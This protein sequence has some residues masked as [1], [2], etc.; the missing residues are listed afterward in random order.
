MKHILNNIKNTSIRIQLISIFI[1]IGIAIG[2]VTVVSLSLNYR[3]IDRHR[4]DLEYMLMI[5]EL[6]EITNEGKKIVGELIYGPKGNEEERIIDVIQEADHLIEKVRLQTTSVDINL[7]L[8]VTQYLFQQYKNKGMDL[9]LLVNEKSDSLVQKLEKTDQYKVYLEIIEVLNRIDTYIQE[10]IT[11]SVQENEEFLKQTSSHSKAL[12]YTLVVVTTVVIGMA[13]YLGIRYSRYLEGL[14]SKVLKLT[15]RISEGNKIEILEVQEGP[16]EIREMTTSFNR[17]IMTMEALKQKADEKAQLE[18]K[19]AEEEL[20]KSRMSEL[21][22]EAQLQGLQFQIQ[23][24]FLF[25]TLN[26]ISM[27]AI[28]ENDRKVYDLIMALSKFMRYSLKKTTSLVDLQE[29]VDMIHQYLYILKARMGTRLEYELVN[30]VDEKVKIPL[31]TLQ[32]IVENAFRHGLEE[33]VGKGRI[34][35]RITK[36]RNR[37]IL[38]VYNDG[39]GMNKEELSQLRKRCKC[40]EVR[41]DQEKHIGIE[42]VVHRLNILFSKN[43]DYQIYSSSIRGTLFTIQ[44]LI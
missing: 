16:E 40:H 42:N 24:H 34:I 19:L 25:N 30:E 1:A 15:K 12:Q 14:I 6:S 18:L 7:R 41:M 21:L 3:T 13:L 28:M 23:P 22:K 44:I 26:M 33:K 8:R 11:Y 43:V 38:R 9:I 4:Q 20:E 5:S 39:I 2:G 17:L 32:P 37:M 27:N 36:R 31:F 10:M 29:E 35:V